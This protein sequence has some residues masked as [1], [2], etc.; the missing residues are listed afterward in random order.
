M[1]RIKTPTLANGVSVVYDS[2]DAEKNCEPTSLA[3]DFIT[4]PIRFAFIFCSSPFF[5]SEEKS[6]NQS[7]FTSKTFWPHKIICIILYFV[8]ILWM[9]GFVRG[10]LPAESRNPALFISFLET[11][12]I[13]T[14]KLAL[15]KALWF[16]KSGIVEIVNYIYNHQEKLPRVAG[17]WRKYL[18]IITCS[19]YCLIGC[20][21]VGVHEDLSMYENQ[22]LG[23]EWW[24]KIVK[25][26]RQIFFIDEITNGVHNATLFRS[27]Q[28]YSAIDTCMG[29][30]AA[31]GLLHRFVYNTKL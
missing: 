17:V 26:G 1:G 12:L 21:T 10:S 6:N 11:V 28:T 13:H 30:L 7:A 18:I 4:I 25:S 14:C 19:C 5:I 16:N 15:A 8:D 29:I 27:N 23:S 31:A 2:H 9:I 24:D 3:C 20:W 22:K